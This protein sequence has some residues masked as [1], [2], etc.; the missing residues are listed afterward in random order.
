MLQKACRGIQHACMRRIE[1][2]PLTSCGKG[3]S[4]ITASLL[5]QQSLAVM[6]P[7][8]HF[9]PSPSLPDRLQDV[10]AHNLTWNGR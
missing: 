2:D 10:L 8:V 9:A 1:N 3:A 5:H 4:R 7:F 6:V